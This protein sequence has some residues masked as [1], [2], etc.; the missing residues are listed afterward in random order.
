MVCKARSGTRAELESQAC[1]GDPKL[2]WAE[3][4]ANQTKLAEGSRRLKFAQLSALR[5]DGDDYDSAEELGDS[6]KQKAHIPVWA[7]D[8][9]F[10]T[11]CGAYAESKAV[12]LKGWC[13]GRPKNDGTWGG[14][15]GQHRKLTNGRHP[16]S[17][18][19][20]PQPRWADGSLWQPGNGTYQNLK[21]TTA[22]AVDDKFYRYVPAPDKV[23]RPQI[24]A[25]SIQQITAERA[26]RV[27]KRQ[28]DNEAV[29]EMVVG[30]DKRM[31]LRSKGPACRG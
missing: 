5:D 29:D 16:K 9:I 10:C 25:I 19:T 13:L 12:R 3:A 26:E 30:D 27:R 24:R 17:N 8:L 11:M 23:L 21:S 14:A 4:A 2:D 20:L 28:R 22:D 31:R 1:K 7:G 6:I 18:A 15:W